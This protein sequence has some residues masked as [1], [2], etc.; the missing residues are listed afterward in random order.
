MGERV[1]FRAEMNK[2]EKPRIK[3]EQVSN[4]HLLRHLC[5]HPLSEE[6]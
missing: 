3:E 5:K 1:S 2:S 6:V 4:L